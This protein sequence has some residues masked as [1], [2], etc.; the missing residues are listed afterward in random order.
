MNGIFVLNKPAGMTSAR[1]LEQVKRLLKASKAGHAGT[2]DPFATGVLVCCLGKATRLSRFLLQGEKSYEGVMQ[3]GLETDT[4]DA[5]GRVLR[6]VPVAGLTREQVETAFERFK[7]TI[8]QKPPLYSALKHKGVPLYKWA[9]QG[10]PVQK[11]A[12]RVQIM[13]IRVLAVDFPRIHFRVTCSAGTYVRALCADIGQ[14]LGC[15]GIL[16]SLCRTVSSGFSIY[17]AIGLEQLKAELA[18][19]PEAVPIVDMA[20][21]L[22]GMPK[23]IADSRLAGM[24]SN[25]RQLTVADFTGKTIAGAIDVKYKSYLAIVDSNRRLLAVVKSENAAGRYDYCCVFHS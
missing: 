19:G 14:V 18:E 17:E 6:E 24:I 1:A 23:A 4:Q 16:Q 8:E 11:P 10:K 22:R 9:R 25:G 7:G 13:D 21:A 15:G 3:L 12:R 5:T 2:L 20:D